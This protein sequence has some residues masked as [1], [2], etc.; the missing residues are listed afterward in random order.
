VCP[1]CGERYFQAQV[2][3]RIDRL[4]MKEHQI[5]QQIQVEVV[6]M[7]DTILAV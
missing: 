3:D 2:L 6:S 1:E 4:L 5:K 7:Q